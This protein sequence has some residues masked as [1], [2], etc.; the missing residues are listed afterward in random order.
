L[1]EL[2]KEEELIAF[3]RDRPGHDL[4]YA[5][6]ISKAE[7]ELQWKPKYNFSIG[8]KETIQWYI[9]HHEWVEHVTSGEYLEYYKQQYGTN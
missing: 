4:R 6:N 1:K 3:V 8:M 5:M 2:G 9:D 7:R